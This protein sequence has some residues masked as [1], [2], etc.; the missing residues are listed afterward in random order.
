MDAVISS[1]EHAFGATLGIWFA[2]VFIGF[3]VRTFHR[4]PPPGKPIPVKKDN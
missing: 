2:I 3:T 1:F 4:K